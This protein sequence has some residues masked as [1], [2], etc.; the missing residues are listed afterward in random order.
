MSLI[1][2][3]EDLRI[4]QE[5]RRLVQ[6][7]YG[8]FIYCKDYSFR[9]QIQRSVIS[10]MNN[11]SEGFERRTKKDFS[12]FLDMAK[13]SSAEAKSMMYVAEDLQYLLPSE[14]SMFRERLSEL[15]VSIGALASKVCKQ[16]LKRLAAK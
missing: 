11:I 4:W 7:T 2:N 1:A 16:E 8:A 15:I 14:A 9:D 6:E 12:H 10:I 13:G 3:F 5:A